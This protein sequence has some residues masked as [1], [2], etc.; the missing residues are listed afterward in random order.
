MRASFDKKKLKH[1]LTPLI[2]MTVKK[3]CAATRQAKHINEK[4]VKYFPE[5]LSIDL[6]VEKKA[7]KNN[8]FYIN[9][10]VVS[11]ILLRVFK[12]TI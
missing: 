6:V 11:I 7:T 9:M 10:S 1:S 5:N 2:P 4:Y 8:L 12:K 3:T